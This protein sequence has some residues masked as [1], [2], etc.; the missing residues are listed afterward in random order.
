[1]SK[2]ILQLIV[3]LLGIL[4]IFAFIALIYGMYSK[5][6]TNSKDM[7]LDRKKISLNLKN[8]EEIIDI[9][10]EIIDENRLLITINSS[11]NFKSMIYNIKDNKINADIENIRF[12][13]C[14]PTWK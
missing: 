8:K 12:V 9:E 4:I 13:L 14:F 1:M 2:K 6:S 11:D 5:I 7:T 10:V 3:I